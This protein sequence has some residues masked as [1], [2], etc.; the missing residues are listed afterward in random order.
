MSFISLVPVPDNPVLA[1]RSGVLGPLLVEVYE[2][3]SGSSK[4]Q[5]I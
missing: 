2:E 4:F 3:V 5:V 1:R